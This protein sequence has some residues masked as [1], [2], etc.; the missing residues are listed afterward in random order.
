MFIQKKAVLAVFLTTVVSATS[1]SAADVIGELNSYIEC[2]DGECS[3]TFKLKSDG[4]LERDYATTTTRTSTAENE[5]K[6]LEGEQ[7]ISASNYVITKRLSQFQKDQISV[8]AKLFN[9][10]IRNGACKDL[11]I[12]L[13]ISSGVDSGEPELNMEILYVSEAYTFYSAG[14][15]STQA[16]VKEKGFDTEAELK[17]IEESCAKFKA[18]KK[19]KPSIKDVIGPAKADH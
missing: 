4:T 11:D 16:Q 6:R 17:R 12:Q 3:V 18:E 13:N 1:A 2:S 9:E 14:L 5:Y 19:L 10:K 7:V 15:P 8:M